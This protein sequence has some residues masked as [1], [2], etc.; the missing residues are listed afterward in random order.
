MTTNVCPSDEALIRVFTTGDSDADQTEIQRHLDQCRKC[1]RRLEQLAEVPKAGDDLLRQALDP[2]VLRSDTLFDTIERISNYDTASSATN[3][4]KYDDVRPWIRLSGDGPS[5]TLDGYTLLECIGRGGMGVVF[6][7]RKPTDERDY[8]LKT[9]QPELASDT[10]ARERFMREARAIASVRHCNVV[11][12]HEV[13]EIDGLPY[14]LME[15]VEGVSLD[16]RLRSGVPM[17]A[18]E[19]VRI[20][21]AVA[22]G[23]EACHSEDV[24]H[25]D[26]KPSNVLLGT[27]DD[28]VKI[29]DFGLAMIASTPKLTF[30]GYLPGTP[31]YVAPE[32]LVIGAE[33]DKRSDL[34]SLGCLLYRMATGEEAFGGDT[35]LITLHRIATQDPEPIRIKNPSIPEPL[36]ETISWLMEKQPED[37]PASAKDAKEALL[38]KA[39]RQ[40]RRRQQ[41]RMVAA[42]VLALIAGSALFAT[43][44]RQQSSAVQSVQRIS[45]TADTDGQ[46]GAQT[47]IAVSTSDDLET[48]V[49][50]IEDGGRIVI[51]TDAT[52]SVSPLYIDGKSVT[53]AAAE[54]RHPTIQLKVPEDGSPPEF[55]LRAYYGTLKLEGLTF[56]DR[57]EAAEH[58]RRLAGNY[59]AIEDYS[60]L[61]L[62]D[63][64]LEV[65]DCRFETGTHG[66]C[67]ALEP[68]NLAVFRS[69]RILA[70]QGTAI[71]LHAIDND[72]LQLNECVI[73]G[74]AGVVTDL[75]GEATLA[76]QSSTVLANI[77]VL[78]LEPRRGQL[79]ARISNCLVQSSQALILCSIEN[80]SLDA[81]RQ[82]L[83]WYGDGNR[84]R[85]HEVILSDGEFEPQWGQEVA[86]WAME[87]REA[88]YR[89]SVFNRPQR[90][91]I[92]Q[93]ID[94]QSIENMVLTASDPN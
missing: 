7:A 39:T 73:V 53:L 88:T 66:A 55:L 72:E 34:F 43:S 87:D 46:P 94:G 49:D 40:P 81:F 90:E 25:R 27:K 38:G 56:Q 69:T 11:A 63:A 29:T 78:E 62:I 10:K 59:S 76:L 54:G 60:L 58:V 84:I 75:E 13:S 64:D 74:N 4:L 45:S 44:I 41:P 17:N 30:H 22:L 85:G 51:D 80:P 2:E 33:A 6:R 8:A 92:Q 65:Q 47:S 3:T 1:Q 68:V 83:A 19:I 14:L 35:P 79:T 70:P 57:W 48:A 28:T 5:E 52:L 71:N 23:I 21:A 89:R 18:D 26:I 82:K 32:R 16:D 77:A 24:I 50:S 93:L 61:S 9:M 12:L 37:R 86:K 42:L 15:H 36:A 91:V 20:G 31:D 67:V